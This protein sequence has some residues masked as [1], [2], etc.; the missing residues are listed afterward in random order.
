MRRLVPLVFVMVLVVSACSSYGGASEETPASTTTGS[1][2]TVTTTV[3]RT[4]STTEGAPTTTM[5]VTTT[6]VGF[7]LNS[8]PT[9]LGLREWNIGIN[10]SAGYSCAGAGKPDVTCDALYPVQY[11]HVWVGYDDLDLP[12]D[13]ID[14]FGRFDKPPSSLTQHDAPPW[15]GGSV[16][17]PTVVETGHGVRVKQLNRR[18]PGLDIGGQAWIRLTISSLSA[19]DRAE[20][21]GA[22]APTEIGYQIEANSEGDPLNRTGRWGPTHFIESI[23][24]VATNE[25]MSQWIISFNQPGAYSYSAVYWGLSGDQYGININFARL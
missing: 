8:F 20:S 5:E 16:D 19:T 3:A 9:A 14:F 2:A 1:T 17:D 4:T 23:V 7:S 18:P 24:L 13:F 12:I 11:T 25:T 22:L 21:N 15:W 6:T 10:E